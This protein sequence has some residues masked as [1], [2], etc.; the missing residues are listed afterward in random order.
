MWLVLL[1]LLQADIPLR[2]TGKRAVDLTWA[3]SERFPAFEGGSPFRAEVVAT[4]EKNGYYGRV[5]HAPEHFATHI[6][7]PAHFG[8]GQKT[9]DQLTADQMFAPAVVLDVTSQAASNAD[10]LLTAAD[11]AAWEKKNGRIAPGSV[12]LLR[13]GWGRRVPDVGAYRNADAS[14]T[15]H[16]PG[17]S[18][19]AAKLL[20]DERRAI[21]FG[22]DN[23]SVDAGRSA[24]FGVHRY[25]Q[26][27]GLYHL[28]NLANLDKLPP[29]VFLVVA[30]IKLEGGSGGQVRVWAIF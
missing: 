3:V 16:S 2:E 15:L 6:D 26:A 24:D 4:I 28:E 29:R 18:P 10:Y 7:A 14:G 27:H 17:F 9:V 19:E 13:T 25:T 1:F 5:Y 11:I 22:I 21:A 8:R 20:V 23:L 12:V 30:P